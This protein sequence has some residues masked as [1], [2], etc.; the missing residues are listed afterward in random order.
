MC[1]VCEEVKKN[2]GTFGRLER[3]DVRTSGKDDR[4]AEGRSKPWRAR[5]EHDEERATERRKRKRDSSHPQADAF[6]G[7]KAKEKVGLLRSE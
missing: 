6:A 5:W 2:V 4:D 7:A 3:L 1:F